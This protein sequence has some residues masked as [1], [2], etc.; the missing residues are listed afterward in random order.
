M[1]NTCGDRCFSTCA[2]VI[3]KVYEFY[4]VWNET[5]MSQDLSNNTIRPPRPLDPAH[6]RNVFRVNG[7]VN[8]RDAALILK[9]KNV[10]FYF[11][12]S[13]ISQNK[14]GNERGQ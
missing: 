8:F 2:C 14:K 10:M 5:K 6:I 9:K 11:L 3:I 7:S 13:L 1:E 4:I 12:F